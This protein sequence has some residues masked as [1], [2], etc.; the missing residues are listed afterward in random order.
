MRPYRHLRNG[1]TSEI[2]TTH[3]MR[4]HCMVAARGGRLVLV[5]SRYTFPLYRLLR[6]LVGAQERDLPHTRLVRIQRS[7]VFPSATAPHE[8]RA[9]MPD[10][11][12][13]DSRLRERVGCDVCRGLGGELAPASGEGVLRKVEDVECAS[14]RGVTA[15]AGVD[16]CARGE[17]AG[18]N[19]EEA[20]VGDGDCVR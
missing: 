15:H 6:I 12:S 19:D 7:H 14:R 18:I 8:E 5:R 2:V 3:V 16:G 1:T 20:G 17:F 4:H 13:S 10:C 9:V 11:S